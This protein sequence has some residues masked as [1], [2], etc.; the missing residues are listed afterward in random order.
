MCAHA[1]THSHT[2]TNSI[3]KGIVNSGLLCGAIFKMYSTIGLILFS[4]TTYPPTHLQ[5]VSMQMVSL[6]TITTGI[7]LP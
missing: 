1:L 2:Y 5:Q 4:F 6:E 7:Y 3:Y